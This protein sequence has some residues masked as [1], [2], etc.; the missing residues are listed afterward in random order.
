MT[1]YVYESDFF[2]ILL[3]Q[4]PPYHPP[5]WVK[6]LGF[7]VPHRS[8][9]PAPWSLWFSVH[10]H[11]LR[12]WCLLRSADTQG[13]EAA[14]CPPRPGE[15]RSV[16]EV[17][18][19][20]LDPRSDLQGSYRH[21]AL[22]CSHLDSTCRE[23]ACPGGPRTQS[24]VSKCIGTVGCLNVHFTQVSHSQPP[25]PGTL[26]TSQ[27]LCPPWSHGGHQK[28]GPPAELRAWG[29]PWLSWGGAET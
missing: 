1:L 5:L 29:E 8:S 25:P 18:G 11:L 12:T 3:T 4:F 27:H 7:S 10:P 17:F 21:Y 22:C 16:C 14:S 26:C 9:G 20:L 2:N 19:A 6:H 28:E 23:L 13:R 15:T 24:Q